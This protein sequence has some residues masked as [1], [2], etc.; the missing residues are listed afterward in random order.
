M[1]LGNCCIINHLYDLK[2]QILLIR[3]YLGPFSSKPEILMD[4]VIHQKRLIDYKIRK[5]VLS[6]PSC[7]QIQTINCCN[8]HCLMCPKQ[9][10][11]EDTGEV[12]SKTLFL[13]IL[14][15]IVEEN[16][17]HTLIHFYLQNEPFMDHDI[18]QKI[19]LTKE[20]S[21]N[22]IHIE[23]VTNGTF[24]S[25]KVIKELRDITID[26]FVIS[27]DAYTK[28]TYEKI[29]RG[30]DFSL[31]LNNIN[32]LIKQDYRGN[33]Y[34]GFVEQKDNFA[35]QQEFKK[36][37]RNVARRS[38]KN[39]YPYITQLSNRSGDLNFFDRITIKNN[40]VK[41]IHT[42][43]MHKLIP[44]SVP[45]LD[46]NILANGDVILCCNDYYKKTILGNVSSSSIKEIWNSPKYNHIRHLL[47][48]QKFHSLPVC[49]NCSHFSYS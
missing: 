23:L 48:N 30:L 42:K 20:L 28:I 18:L 38:K 17:S 47:I 35:E 32:N 10:K 15:E 44:C 7:F 13:K 16:I 31:V 11:T 8:G 25:E 29:R 19:R 24:L 6:F 33:I 46:F 43:F 3:M 1:I 34:I 36:Y 27:V 9:Q 22:K 26:I 45:F 40:Y 14:K 5:Q 49:K 12:M 37:W 2:K 41:Q 39:I 21:K 4:S